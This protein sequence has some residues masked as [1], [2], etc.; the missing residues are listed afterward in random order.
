[1]PQLAIQSLDDPRLG[2]Y[3]DLRN[4]RAAGRGGRFIAEGDLLVARLL[5]SPHRVESLLVA[6]EESP[7]WS[8][9][10]DRPVYVAPRPLLERLVGFKFHRGVLACGLRPGPREL[11]DC[12]PPNDQDCAVVICAAVQD[13]ENLGGILRNAAAFGVDLVV[14]G[15]ASAD[16]LSRRVLR[17]SMGAALNLNLYQSRDLDQDLQ[18][19]RDAY[20]VHLAASVADPAAPALATARRPPRWGLLLGNER[21]GLS[22]AQLAASDS[23]WTIPMPGRI[24]SLNV[25]VASAIFLYHFQIDRRA[26]T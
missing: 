17:V 5:A 22:P 9:P 18:R 16:P 3:R 19:L 10:D 11:A 24:D 26:R 21:H 4:K 2:A 7:R 12:L 6:T 1:M 8:L 13:P 20:A 14:V 23:Q 15:P 25:A